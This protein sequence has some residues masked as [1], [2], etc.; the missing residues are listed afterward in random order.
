MTSRRDVTGMMVEPFFYQ[1]ARDL[2]ALTLGFN[3]DVHDGILRDLCVQGTSVGTI[4]AIVSQRDLS[5][6]H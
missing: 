2:G 4:P 3:F 5:W 1:S 6:N